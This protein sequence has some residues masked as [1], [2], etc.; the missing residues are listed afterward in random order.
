MGRRTRLTDTTTDAKGGPVTVKSLAHPI[1][2]AEALNL[3]GGD[4][5]RLVPTGD[6]TTVLVVRPRHELSAP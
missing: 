3:A 6:P 4:V 5:G 2:W 1:A